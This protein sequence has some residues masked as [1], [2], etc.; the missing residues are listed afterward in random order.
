MKEI[1]FNKKSWHYRLVRRVFVTEEL[2]DDICEYIRKVTISL[3]LLLLVIT[4]VIFAGLMAC[5]GAYGIITWIYDCIQAGEIIKPSVVATGG[6]F[7]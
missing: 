7:M 6:L 1:T 5:I 4:V 2:G 3:M